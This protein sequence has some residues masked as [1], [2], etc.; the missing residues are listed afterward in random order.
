MHTRTR[1]HLFALALPILALTL[2]APV[3]AP[4]TEQPR[5]QVYR[6]LTPT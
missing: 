4:Q 3:T 2:A 1:R 5:K 6:K